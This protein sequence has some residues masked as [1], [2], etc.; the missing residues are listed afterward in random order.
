MPLF[1]HM[2]KAGFLMMQLNFKQLAIFCDCTA[3]FLFDVIEKPEDRFYHD[4]AQV[5]IEH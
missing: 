2:P 5:L 4:W 3:W 1:S